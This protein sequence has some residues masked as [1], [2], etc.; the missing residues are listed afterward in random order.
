MTGFLFKIHDLQNV[1]WFAFFGT[2]VGYNFVKYDALVR[3]KKFEIK[4]ELKL[5]A[6]L[7]FVSFLI[8]GCFFYQLQP[9]TQLIGFCF[10]ALTLLYTLPF[11]PTKRNARNWAGLKIYIVAICWVGVTL[12]L[13]IINS[14]FPFTAEVFLVSIQRFILV[15]V[16]ILLFEI[17]DLKTDDPH[18]NRCFTVICFF[19][20][21]IF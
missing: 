21:R 3:E 18:S 13:P 2:I 17:V 10:L 6:I 12:L 14:N 9:K 8:S 7:S 5:I 11:F 19:A 4:P 1:S 16:L 20:F 15:F